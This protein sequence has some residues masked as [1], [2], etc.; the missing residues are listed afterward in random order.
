MDAVA[1]GK[2]VIQYTGNPYVDA[3]AAVLELRL[4]KPCA[5][6]GEDDLCAQ[7]TQL[8]AEYSRPIW[9]SYLT[10]HFPNS[11]WVQPRIS[12]EKKRAYVRKVLGSYLEG[13]L[14][15]ARGCAFCGRSAQ[16]IVD[17]SHFPLLTGETIMVA[18]AGA[19]PGLP[20]CGFCIFAVQFYPLATLKVGGRPLFW[21]APEP[22][23]TRLLTRRFLADSQRVLAASSDQFLNLR[24]ASTQLLRA[25][26]GA[27]DDLDNPPGWLSGEKRPPLCDIVG[28]HATN[29]GSGPD[30]DELRIPRN[31][32]EFWSEARGSFGAI[33]QEIE[34]EAWESQVKRKSSKQK[35]SDP[36]S[37]PELE[38]RNVLY[39][40]LGKS[41]RS[42]DFQQEAK[43]VASRFFL[44]RKVKLVKP[45]TTALAEF[46]L[47][48]VASMQKARLEA[49]RSIADALVDSQDAKWIIDRLMRSG[50]DL[51]GYITVLRA[52][53][54]KLSKGQKPIS[55]D[56]FL[57]AL[58]L[59]NDED[60][61]ASDTWLVSELVLIRIFERLGQERPEVLADI[62]A[63][64]DAQPTGQ[65]A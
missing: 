55:W 6:F 42:A 49:I 10:I 32:L 8:E 4:K 43:R 36:S 37:V 65:T 38:R 45:N 50:R 33:Y 9:K 24:W 40:A 16:T 15:P 27:M 13:P 25:A 7:A 31:L 20:V 39:E 22:G 26:R 52:V 14:V 19:E 54:Q 60:A 51:R 29:F 3:G 59:A 41:F 58:N 11:A 48:K 17:R 34:T 46:F 47:E 1:E 12:A 56:V 28:I 35:A 30:Y 5:T 53:Q 63:P 62:P 57:L 2:S 23:W 64:E 61:T 44:R 18:G 21:W